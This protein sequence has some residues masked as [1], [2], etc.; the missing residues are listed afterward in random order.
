[1][2]ENDIHVLFYNKL[3]ILKLNFV[4][5]GKLE[6]SGVHIGVSTSK[7]SSVSELTDVT[8]QNGIDGITG[9]ATHNDFI[10]VAF[11][12]STPSKSGKRFQKPHQVFVKFTH[13]ENGTSS[14]FVGAPDGQLDGAVG[15]KFRS[16]ASLTKETETF[17]RESGAYTV[18]ILAADAAYSE[19]IEWIIGT[20]ELTFPAT[21]QKS[22]PL[23]TKPLLFES[24]NSLT[25]LPEIVHLMRPA[26]KRASSFMASVFTILS[27]A[28]LIL[29]IGFLLSLKPNL[30]RLVSFSSLCFVGCLATAAI[31]YLG[32][33]FS[34]D[35]F[36]F[37]DTIKYLCFLLPITVVVGSYAIPS[38][39]HARLEEAKKA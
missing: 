9:S 26:S 14:Y 6:V 31:L 10:H 34:L 22:Y 12:L 37:Y 16:T 19:P 7:E 2:L 38:V 36:S 15:S 17:M 4:I 5:Q 11:T 8:V 28:P 29:F 24:D 35:G 3:A 23:Y 1:M 39:T 33:W 25:A 21:V 13:L 30:K 27:I 18:S 32:Y 20:A